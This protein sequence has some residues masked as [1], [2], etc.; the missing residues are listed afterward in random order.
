MVVGEVEKIESEREIG[1]DGVSDEWER[2]M[3]ELD[4]AS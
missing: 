4:Q 1:W 3:V 2:E